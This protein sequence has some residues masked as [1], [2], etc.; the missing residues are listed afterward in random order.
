MFPNGTM[1]RVS[2]HFPKNFYSKQYTF[3]HG[4]S[5]GKLFETLFV[6]KAS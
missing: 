3:T 4:D 1:L 6:K 5:K 2:T